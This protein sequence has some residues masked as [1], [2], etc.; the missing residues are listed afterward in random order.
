MFK[1]TMHIKFMHLKQ[2][3]K[4]VKFQNVKIYVYFKQNNQK[5]Y[6]LNRYAVP[7]FLSL[8]QQVY[9]LQAQLRLI[10]FTYLGRK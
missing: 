1:T 8:P 4:N 10:V 3:F 5:F 2:D 9:V 7:A 6:N